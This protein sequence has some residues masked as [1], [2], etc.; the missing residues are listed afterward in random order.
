M[1][2]EIES[3]VVDNYIT[4]TSDL[5]L[6]CFD[7]IDDAQLPDA[8]QDFISILMNVNNTA[9][10]ELS[11]S[12][13]H[14]VDFV[15]SSVVRSHG[16]TL[17]EECTLETKNEILKALLILPDY[18]DVES[19]I[20]IGECDY[21][22]IEK[23]IELLKLVILADENYFIYIEE[24]S[25]SL[26]NTLMDLSI[27]RLVPEEAIDHSAYINAIKEYKTF[28][29]PQELEVFR[30][31]EQGYPL[32]MDISYYY[33]YLHMEDKTPYNIAKEIMGF[34]L[35][36]SSNNGDVLQILKDTIETISSDIN[37]ISLI[38]FQMVR[39]IQEFDQHKIT[40]KD[41]IKNA[42]Q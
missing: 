10:G 33:N 42:S 9:T 5:L 30:L 21:T 20:R 25:D 32:G 3:F 18:D 23:F 28:I 38:N 7:T 24:V 29:Q 14:H 8:Y 6:D 40:L 17:S 31:I 34:I 16:I 27:R 4:E 19:I 2:P 1:L 15:I 26:I 36:S 12:F 22:S 11:N 13:Y 35:I 37:L 39:L 41:K